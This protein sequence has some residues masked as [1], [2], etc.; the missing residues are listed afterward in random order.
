MKNLDNFEAAMRSFALKS[1][2]YKSLGRNDHCLL[3]QKNLLLFG[4]F[5]LAKY[6]TCD[7]GT[8]QLFW[9]IGIPA[10]AFADNVE[11]IDFDLLNQG[12]M[13]C[14]FPYSLSFV[15]KNFIES[16]KST[17]AFTGLEDCF[18]LLCHFLL[19]ATCHWSQD[20]KDQLDERPR[21]EAIY[22]ECKNC[23]EY[24]TGVSGIDLDSLVQKLK[25]LSA[26]RTRPFKQHMEKYF[27]S[28][29]HLTCEEWKWI[30][31]TRDLYFKNIC[32]ILNHDSM[33]IKTYTSM[34]LGKTVSNDKKIAKSLKKSLLWINFGSRNCWKMDW[35]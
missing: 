21:I 28:N 24:A 14:F 30:F 29:P 8:D 9:I 15:I 20:I 4:N 25:F 31:D 33:M 17:A 26:Y 10:S 12:R 6:L 22:D 1:Q 2:F 27:P 3:L 7:K 11:K 32:K 23:V 13:G 16:M 5:I 18:G 34:Q 35:E 19:F